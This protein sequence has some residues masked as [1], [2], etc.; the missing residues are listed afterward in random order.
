MGAKAE[1]FKL[2]Q[3]TSSIL[4][5]LDNEIDEEPFEVTKD[6][7]LGM[8]EIECDPLHLHAHIKDMESAKFWQQKGMICA[9]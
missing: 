9:K 7:E 8:P 3:A 1:G 4:K 6:V 2:R 5:G